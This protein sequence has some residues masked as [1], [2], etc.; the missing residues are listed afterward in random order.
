[1]YDAIERA[2]TEAGKDRAVRAVLVTGEGR[3]FC[4]GADLK[5]HRDRDR[6]RPP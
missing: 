2:V 5:A 1:M 6:G 3:A 4:V